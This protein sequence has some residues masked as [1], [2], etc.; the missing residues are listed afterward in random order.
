MLGI[1]GPGDWTSGVCGEARKGGG[2]GKDKLASRVT[3][4]ALKESS[5]RGESNSKV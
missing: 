4:D 3:A 1:E 5:R 2:S